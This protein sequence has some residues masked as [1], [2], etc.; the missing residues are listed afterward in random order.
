MFVL[1]SKLNSKLTDELRIPN[2]DPR[3]D[4]RN[5]ALACSSS[6]RV[7]NPKTHWREAKYSI[8]YP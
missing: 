4:P 7:T 3:D 6:P 8:R 1:V 2:A 5:N